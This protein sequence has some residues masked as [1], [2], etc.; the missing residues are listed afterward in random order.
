MSERLALS[1]LSKVIKYARVRQRLAKRKDVA[2]LWRHR[3]E[4]LEK[5]RE[6]Q[7]GVHRKKR[8]AT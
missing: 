2:T 6:Q 8:N 4:A 7:F 3:A 5:V 1:A